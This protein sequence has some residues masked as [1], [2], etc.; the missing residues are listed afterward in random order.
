MSFLAE[1][2]MPVIVAA[3]VV[4]LLSSV[5]H[6]VLP[7]HRGD[8]G[9]LPDEDAVLAALREHGVGPGMYMFP[10]PASMKDMDAPEFKE[11]LAAGPVG[12]MTVIPAE[13]FHIGR[14][15]I[16]WFI[17]LLVV[18]VLCAYLGWHALGPGAARPEVLRVIGTA[19]ILGYAVG[20][21]HDSIWQGARWAVTAR[22]VIDGIIYGLATA[23]VFAWL[24]P[25]A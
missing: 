19:A 14:R 10:C 8:Y 25:E 16:G 15:L 13:S 18:S 11:K 22:F 5:I 23:A 12:W 3:V 6:M 9:R 2:W 21:L 24:W 4:F 1:L 17:Y 7:L 20:H